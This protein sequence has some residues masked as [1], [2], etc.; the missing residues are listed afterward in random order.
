MTCF[1][2]RLWNSISFRLTLNYGLMAILTTLILI[3]FIYAQFIGALRT[4]YTRQITSTAQHL[5]VAYEEGGRNALVS[6]IELTLSDRIDADRE[7]YLLLDEH[8]RKI[9]GNLDESLPL[10]ATHTEVYE[11]DIIHDA[12][13]TRGHLK[14][15]TLA[16]GETLVVGHDSSEIGDITSLIGRATATAILLAVLLV[17]LGTYIF[18]RELARRVSHIRQTTQQIGAGQLSKR[19]SASTGEDEF[20]LLNRDVNAMLDRIELLMKSARHISDTIAHNLRTPLTRIVGALRTARRPGVSM[21]E[22]LD[23]NQ[24]A[25]ESIER[26]NVLLEKLLQI[27][28]L[29][30]GIQRRSFRPCELDVIVADVLEMYGTLAEEKGVS[31]LRAKLDDVTLHGDANLLASALA[32]L[33]DNA[34]KFAASRVVVDVTRQ[35]RTALVTITD[36]G[37]GLPPAEYEHLGKHFYRADPSSEGHGL[38]LT[39]VKSIVGLHV[40]TLGFSDARPGLRVT[41]SLPL[42]PKS[43]P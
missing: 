43:K 9:A 1:L 36:D 31:L 13:P 39:S 25:I 28:E 26:L 2:R 34:V 8:G 40:G 6:A 29:E 5:E 33:I 41:V 16:G 22:V 27:A 11:A 3:V 18:R 17:L 7:I 30:A 14:V 21:A 20:T 32:N 38:G 15:L 42:D 24:H 19:I 35:D 10:D 4:E 37:A 12:V 23:A